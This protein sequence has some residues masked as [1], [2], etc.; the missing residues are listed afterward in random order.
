MAT[1]KTR[2]IGHMVKELIAAGWTEQDITALA[3]R[4]DISQDDK[5]R[6]QAVGARA[7]NAV[8]DAA[9]ELHEA[10]ARREAA[11]A[12]AAEIHWTKVG[13]AWGITGSGLVEGAE[14]TVT[15][16]DGTTSTET[17][18]HII[19]DIDGIQIATTL[20]AERDARQSAA[21]DRARG[22][23]MQDGGQIF[24]YA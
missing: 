24:D 4:G 21:R 14:V 6:W 12:K 8:R 11:I 17:V 15:R 5:G 16:R 13:D 10:A 7:Y 20:Q 9:Q 19:S 23:R 2:F 3:S 18:A 1:F 22:Y